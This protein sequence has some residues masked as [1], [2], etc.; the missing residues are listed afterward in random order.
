VLDLGREPGLWPLPLAEIDGPTGVLWALDVSQALFD[1][2]AA[3]QPPAQVR[4]LRSELPAIDLPDASVY[5]VWGAFVVHEVEP[6][7]DLIREIRQVLRPGGR[8]AL[9]DGR[10]DAIHDDGPPRHHRLTPELV[11]MHLQAAGFPRV[12]QTWQNADGYLVEAQ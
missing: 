1:P 5:W 3:R 11:S 2:L 9:L 10:P 4:L 7:A 6:L 12:A 8:V